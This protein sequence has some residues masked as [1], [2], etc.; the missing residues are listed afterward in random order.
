MTVLAG[1]AA[2]AMAACV[3]YCLVGARASR[4]SIWKKRTSRIALR[5]L[6]INLLVLLTA[7]RVLQ[8]FLAEPMLTLHRNP[9][10]DTHAMSAPYRADHW[11]DCTGDMANVGSPGRHD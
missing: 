6:A 8:T 9:A 7:R 10:P 3:G 11:P 5:R 1:I 2:L 4:P